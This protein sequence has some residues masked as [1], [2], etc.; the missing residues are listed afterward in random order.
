MKI[1]A[2]WK[3][4]LNKNI[5]I[6]VYLAVV[7]TAQKVNEWKN[8]NWKFSTENEIRKEIK[9]LDIGMSVNIA[10]VDAAQKK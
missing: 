5:G 6:S 10:F 9:V 8:R 2:K 3:K 4:N 1:N 7:N